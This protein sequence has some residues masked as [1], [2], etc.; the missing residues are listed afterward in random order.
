MVGLAR[1]ALH[2]DRA[3]NHSEVEATLLVVFH[4]VGHSSIK[5]LK[6][7]LAL[8]RRHPLEEREQPCLAARGTALYHWGFP[9]IPDV[10]VCLALRGLK[11]VVLKF[12][13]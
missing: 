2:F 12:L 10:M 3:L 11:S 9:K 13:R 7:L 8:R 4:C 5:L 1:I 6:H